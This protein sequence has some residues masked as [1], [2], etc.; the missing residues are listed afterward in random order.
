M[1][2]QSLFDGLNF[3]P[4][5]LAVTELL[6]SGAFVDG[7]EEFGAV[8]LGHGDTH[9]LEFV[10]QFAFT[11]DDVDGGFCRGFLRHIGEDFFVGIRQ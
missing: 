6:K 2:G 10:Y 7:I 1:T 4:I 9:F 8:D 5:G 3:I 11:L